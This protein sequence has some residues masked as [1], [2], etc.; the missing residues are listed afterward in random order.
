[1]TDCTETFHKA[2]DACS[3]AGG[4]KI[5]VPEGVYLTGAIHLKSNM[6]LDL[7]KGAT[8]R[9]STDPKSYLPTVF[10]RYEGTE[11]MNY[12]PFIYAFGQENIAITGEGTIDGQASSSI[13]YSWKAKSNPDPGLL[14]EMGNQGVPVD[15]RIFGEGRNL[16]PNFIEPVRCKNVLIEGVHVTNSPMWVLHP[17]YCT[18]VTISG[19]TVDTHGPNTD[20]CD[21][22]SCTDVLIKNCCFSDGDDCIAIKSGKDVDGRRVNTPSRNFVIQNCVFKD[23]HGGVTVG[24]EVSGGVENVLAE[25]CSF[26]S[27]NL[28]IAMR[29][30]T[31]MTRGGYIKNINIRNCTVKSARTGIGMTM[32]YPGTLDGHATPIIQ[33]I[34]IRNCTFDNLSK[35]PIFIEGFSDSGANHRCDG[36]QLHFPK[37]WRPE[38]HHQCQPHTFDRQ[39]RRRFGFIKELEPFSARCIQFCLF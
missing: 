39:P 5:A 37:H 20:G 17:L 10:T 34:D 28:D 8:I 15:Q 16:R 1:M 4:G 23:G 9:F 14:I 32:R 38:H 21:P 33:D 18:N 30:K 25:N 22:D 19:V 24:S 6:D 13:W 29:F 26:D 7:A 12:S 2:I 11:V 3:R 31:G 36:C 27:T 35:Q